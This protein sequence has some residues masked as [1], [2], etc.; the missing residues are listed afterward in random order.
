MQITIITVTL[1]D[2]SRL[3]RTAISVMSQISSNFEWVI[4]DGYSNDGTSQFLAELEIDSRIKCFKQIPSGIYSAMNL[5]AQNASG[6]YLWFLNAGDCFNSKISVEAASLELSENRTEILITPVIHVDSRNR[7][8]DLS[9]PFILQNGNR[10]EAHVNHQGVLVATK[11]FRR[12]NGF[13]ANLA[14]AA[15]GK[16]LD[17]AVSLEN[18]LIGKQIYVSFEIGGT[19]AQNF[20]ST[21]R[22]IATYRN[23]APRGLKLR[24]LSLRNSVKLCIYAADSYLLASLALRPLFK[25]RTRKALQN[26]S[27]SQLT[28]I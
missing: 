15:D 21:V 9:I 28:I 16:F 20:E 26:I 4:V 1:N 18:P 8:Q 19:A 3:K 11:L 13:D 24:Y 7:V 5:G 25:R 2:L 14:L 6:D 12:L 22:E 23:D 27:T 10:K 17:Q